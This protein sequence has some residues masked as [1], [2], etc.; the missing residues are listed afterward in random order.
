MTEQPLNIVA[1][2]LEVKASG[3]QHDPLDDLNLDDGKS[4]AELLNE[5]KEKNNINK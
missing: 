2:V 4:I 3:M 1:S 5:Q